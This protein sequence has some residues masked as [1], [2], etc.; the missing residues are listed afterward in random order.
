VIIC[1]SPVS[2]SV[3]YLKEGYYFAN[4][5]TDDE[6]LDLWSLKDATLSQFLFS[7]G[8][9]KSIGEAKKAIL[10]GG[11]RINLIKYENPN[12]SINKILTDLPINETL[13]D[14]IVFSHGRRNQLVF[15][16][17]GCKDFF[18]LDPEVRDKF[19]L[20]EKQERFILFAVKTG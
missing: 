8:L 17:E 1:G 4:G 9:L 6:D 2:F 20:N 13:G 3:P 19:V 5:I 11:V 7:V 10:G 16:K 15:N 18:V 14:K 12:E